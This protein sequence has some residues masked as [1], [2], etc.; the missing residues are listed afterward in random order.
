MFYKANEKLSEDTLKALNEF[1]EKL[2]ED[3]FFDSLKLINTNN[4]RVFNNNLNMSIVKSSEILCNNKVSSLS[5]NIEPDVSM[6]GTQINTND[7][8]TM[9]LINYIIYENST[10]L[11]NV[12]K[13]YDKKFDFLDWIENRN[14]NADLYDIESFLFQVV[15][16]FRMPVGMKFC[17]YSLKINN[18]REITIMPMMNSV[19]NS[20]KNIV[21]PFFR[22][23]GKYTYELYLIYPFNN[24][25][26]VIA[27]NIDMDTKTA[28]T[29]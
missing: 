22:K 1:T 21:I 25:E 13:Y 24:Y 20:I 5:K 23:V 11:S 4:P 12:R 10:I 29:I 28:N 3:L 19:T 26:K 27:F 2:N 16:N 18:G 15:K 6:F 8:K 17:I 7:N 14:S 9:Q